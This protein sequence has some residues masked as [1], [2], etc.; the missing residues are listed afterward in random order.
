MG[1][2]DPATKEFK[3]GILTKS[4]RNSIKF[5]DIQSTWI[6]FDGNVEVEWVENLNSVLDDNRK[7]SLVTG[8]S[9]PLTSYTRIVIESNTLENCSPATISRCGIIYMSNKSITPKAILN[10]YI[11]NFPLILSDK[12]ARFDQ[13]LNYFIPDVLLMLEPDTM[14]YPLK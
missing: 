11:R 5:K 3:E 7:P 9:L 6:I 1:T 14:I 13:L 4:M 8:E 10:Q 2:V 12:K